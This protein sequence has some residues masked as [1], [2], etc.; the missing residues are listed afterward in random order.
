MPFG[1]RVENKRVYIN[2]EEAEIVRSIFQ[3]YAQGVL[4]R[5][6]IA[7]LQEKGITNHGRPFALNTLYNMLRMKK[8]I[9]IF[10][11]GGEVCTNIF[12]P[13][14]PEAL[15]EEVGSILLKNKHG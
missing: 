7:Q 8:Y 3:Q 12:P 4:G 6:L 14:V 13:I 2:E 9:G 5:E 10:E 1:Y 11:Y 15:F